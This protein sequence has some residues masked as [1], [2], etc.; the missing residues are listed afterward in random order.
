MPKCFWKVFCKTF[1]KCFGRNVY[2][3]LILKHFWKAPFEM[4]R[5]CFNWNVWEMYLSK[6]LQ[7]FFTHTKLYKRFHIVYILFPKYIHG[8]QFCGHI[9][10]KYKRFRINAYTTFKRSLF[11]TFMFECFMNILEET[12]Q[13]RF[14]NKNLETFPQKSFRNVSI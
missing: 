1:P 2:W 5:K 10:P 6:L 14:G 3:K 4:F 7:D 12:F 9:F 8:T 13:R 11:E